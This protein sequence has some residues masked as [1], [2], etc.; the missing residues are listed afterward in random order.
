M[1]NLS[2]TNTL[3]SAFSSSSKLWVVV[4]G[5]FLFFR[6]CKIVYQFRKRFKRCY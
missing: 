2:I 5:G 4:I 1:E 3:L 6:I